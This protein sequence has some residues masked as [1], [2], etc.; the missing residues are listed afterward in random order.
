[1]VF[2]KQVLAPAAALLWILLASAP[3]SRAD[4][5][6]GC[7]TCHQGL[8]DKPS[9]LFAHDI[10][11]ARGVTCAG[12]H[13]GNAS[14]DDMEQAMN[15]TAGF[16]GK[17]V[18]DGISLMCARCH[19]D[20]IRMASFHSRIP[21]GQF[22]ALQQSVHGRLSLNGKERMVQ[23]TTCHGAHG[24]LAVS[25]PSSPVHPLNVVATCTSCHNN[26]KY[27]R[28]YNPGLAVDQLEKYRTSVHG[29]RNA[30]G[31]GRVAECASCHGSHGILQAKDVRSRVYPTNIPG[32]CASC[33][34]DT[35]HMRGYGI[36]TDQFAK[37]SMSVHGIALLEK[38]DLGAP[39]CNGCHG[40][41]GATPPGVES[42]SKVC[43][44]C[45]ALNADLFSSSPHKG[46]FDAANL[47]ECETCHGNHEILPATSGLL[48]V[49][50][51]ALCIRCHSAGDSGYSTAGT[52]RV[53]VDSLELGEKSARS[54]VEEA[55]QKGMEIAEAKFRLRDTRQAALEARTMVHSFDGA[56]FAAVIAK[57]LATNS[58]VAEE[59]TK[60]VQEFYFRRFGLGVATLIIT[61]L[62]V[63]LYVYV[64]RIE[65]RQAGEGKK[66]G[67]TPLA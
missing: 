61:V 30:A 40:N 51:D 60:T 23:C 16:L 45:H 10:H 18:G 20:S 24:I 54:L 19:S 67:G 50:P 5:R 34:S 32:T 33:H 57:G 37:Y 43:G 58:S 42:I 8:G 63:S 65:R 29:V 56:R 64:R 21:T 48:G 9:A 2:V 49:G 47:P 31:D 6:D 3:L 25:N 27:M 26:A 4:A 38:K 44:T 11:A 7:L 28:Q 22:A 13:G 12:C 17:P 35:V 1:M 62:A 15:N 53:L 41:H 46:A 39:A 66:T 36:P 14:T 52:M 59:A 55:E